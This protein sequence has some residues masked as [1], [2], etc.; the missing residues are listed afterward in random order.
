MS[1]S[2]NKLKAYQNITQFNDSNAK[3]ILSSDR[4]TQALDKVT[5]RRIEKGEKL[6]LLYPKDR[7]NAMNHCL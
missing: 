7:H 2:T 5:F 4:V 1:G 3:T 6:P